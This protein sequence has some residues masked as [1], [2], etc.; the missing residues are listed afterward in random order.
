MLGRETSTYDY[1]GPQRAF[2]SWGNSDLVQRRPIRL[3]RCDFASPIRVVT[4]YFG[5]PRNEKT[6]MPGPF[7]LPAGGTLLKIWPTE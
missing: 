4:D 5:K 2:E 1:L 3:V 6:P 7:E